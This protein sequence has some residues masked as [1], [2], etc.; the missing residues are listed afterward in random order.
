MA[1]KLLCIVSDLKN[2]LSVNTYSVWKGGEV[3][4]AHTNE[5]PVRALLRTA[6]QAH[7]PVKEVLMLATD[8]AMES[9]SYTVGDK[10]A[11]GTAQQYL[12][13]SIAE[14]CRQD[15][16]PLCPRTTV[17]RCQ[18]DRFDRCLSG[19]L[20]HVNSGD[21][22][23]IDTTGGQRDAANWL[24]LSMQV[25]KYA[26]VNIGCIAYSVYD[27]QNSKKNRV[28]DKTSQY[29]GLDLMQAVEE[30][31][32]CGRAEKLA[33]FFKNSRSESVKQLCA[34]MKNF[35]D[36]LAMCRTRDMAEKICAIQ[37][38][39]RQL[40][41][42]PAA[43]MGANEQL[44]LAMLPLLEQNFITQE[45]AG[46]QQTQEL[47]HWC[48]NA[49]LGMP[50]LALFRENFPDMLADAGLLYPSEELKRA[51][52]DTP[53]KRDNPNTITLE[54]VLFENTLEDL[55]WNTKKTVQEQTLQHPLAVV[56]Q[57]NR[58]NGAA[59]VTTLEENEL[60]RMLCYYHFLRAMRN[61]AMHAGGRAD[62]LF[63]FETREL[64]LP[65]R[66]EDVGSSTV[67][68]AINA[69]LNLLENARIR[70]RK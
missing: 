46:P 12:E 17:I 61:T 60:C 42:E 16:L 2:D 21:E 9:K 54:M 70:R 65:A 56:E 39:M 69:V 23:Y 15:G 59:I 50:A 31:T 7:R 18:F 10:P 68:N 5:A 53:K 48:C 6:G 13:N 35:T 47:I 41:N 28:E 3:T 25:L 66:L 29:R 4:G 22:V 36:T 67:C 19:L 40:K 27:R 49:G 44:F 20:A 62:R 51:L 45:A 14:F 37:N 43:R 58:A 1:V 64:A 11:Q 34:R 55:R 63:P 30:F 33:A 52:L 8:V 24:V 38:G 32:A 57:L 26:K